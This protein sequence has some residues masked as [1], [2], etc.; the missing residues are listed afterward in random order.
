MLK[1]IRSKKSGSFLKKAEPR[2]SNVPS[3]SGS[4]DHEPNSA[5]HLGEG[6][7]KELQD[8]SSPQDLQAYLNKYIKNDLKSIGI[9]AAEFESRPAVPMQPVRPASP[10]RESSPDFSAERMAEMGEKND[11]DRPILVATP[12]IDAHFISHKQRSGSG[13]GQSSFVVPPA[14][15]CLTLSPSRLRS[16]HHEPKHHPAANR[17]SSGGGIKLDPFASTEPPSSAR[18]ALQSP[19]PARSSKLETEVLT[20][21]HLSGTKP[22]PALHPKKLQSESQQP[23]A[24]TTHVPLGQIFLGASAG[25]EEKKAKPP[26]AILEKPDTAV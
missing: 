26:A 12:K 4:A 7:L 19:I 23:I 15:A 13:T 5:R 17:G 9:S 20:A 16:A 25:A 2:A 1:S 6:R 8:L 22:N 11:R 3:D 10:D 14:A 18:S 24:M 21:P